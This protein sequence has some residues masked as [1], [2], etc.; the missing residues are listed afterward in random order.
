MK[1]NFKQIYMILKRWK[2]K[3]LSIMKNYFKVFKKNILFFSLVSVLLISG[4][5]CLHLGT[6]RTFSGREEFFYDKVSEVAR[7][8]DDDLVVMNIK[9]K[10]YNQNLYKEVFDGYS[11]NSLY[12]INTI[13][14]NNYAYK[15]LNKEH[16]NV[17]EYDNS[18]MIFPKGFSSKEKE[19]FIDGV[20]HLRYK[21]NVL[22]LYY[23]NNPVYDYSLADH[24]CVISYNYALKIK[25]ERRL[26]SIDD[27]VGEII[28]ISFKSGNKDKKIK[29]FISAI[30][31]S[32]LGDA[33]MFERI[34]GNTILS[35]FANDN[36]FKSEVDD[37]S[38]SVHLHHD[39]L[40]NKKT[41]NYF[42]EFYN[43]GNSD[44][45]FYSGNNYLENNDIYNS[46]CDL[47][48]NMFSERFNSLIIISLIIYSVLVALIVYFILIKN[49]FYFND[50]S[51]FLSFLVVI[52]IVLL[53]INEI[54]LSKINNIRINNFNLC[55]GVYNSL[56][57]SLSLLIIPIIFAIFTIKMILKSKEGE[58]NAK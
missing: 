35:W 5:V 33:E 49:R 24:F 17:D 30:Y 23:F 32:N 57:S 25:E 7:N 46:Y 18:T 20:K 21:M 43:L 8:S 50:D 40:N 51:K 16:L 52:S 14:K 34:Y 13:F 27:V 54:V 44:Y 36:Y 19:V 11:T 55:Y 47:I 37:I 42:N 1:D 41:I 58:E 10:E 9:P 22:N 4:T 29:L 45:K 2:N 15:V 39:Y 26:S 48:D 31:D 56:A 6:S 3:I 53:G 38:F 28:S 12:E